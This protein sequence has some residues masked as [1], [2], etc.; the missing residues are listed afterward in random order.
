MME[1]AR[2]ESHL[3]DNP[4]QKP[5]LNDLLMDILGVTNK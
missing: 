5:A 2:D 3:P 4:T 1:N